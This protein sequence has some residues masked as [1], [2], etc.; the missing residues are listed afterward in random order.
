LDNTKTHLVC[1]LATNKS[2]YQNITTSIYQYIDISIYQYVN[3]SIYQ[4]I[5]M[6]IYQYINTSLCIYTSSHLIS[7]LLISSHHIYHIPF[8]YFYPYIY[9]VD[10]ITYI[11]DKKPIPYN[12]SIYQYHIYSRQ[13]T[14]QCGQQNKKITD[15]TWGWFLRFNSSIKNKKKT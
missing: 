2:I 10:Y 1:L 5:N 11:P 7:A 6:S 12:N 9:I 15:Q 4:Y 8:L 14:D 3:I 13:Y